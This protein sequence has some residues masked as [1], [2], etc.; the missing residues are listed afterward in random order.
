[1]RSKPKPKGGPP[2]SPPAPPSPAQGALR[3]FE[4]CINPI[5]P[6]VDHLA[7]VLQSQHGPLVVRNAHASMWLDILLTL[8]GRWLR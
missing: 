4:V 8:E 6:S 1:M 7:E 3:Q 5:E 2:V